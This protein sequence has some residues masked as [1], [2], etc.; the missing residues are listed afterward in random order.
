VAFVIVSRADGDRL[1]IAI[2]SPPPYL[3]PLTFAALG[4]STCALRGVDA[5]AAR[6]DAPAHAHREMRARG[7]RRARSAPARSAPYAA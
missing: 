7:L 3:P 2:Q 6:T 5:P 4:T 1:V